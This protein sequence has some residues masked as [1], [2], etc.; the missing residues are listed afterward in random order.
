MMPC[1]FPSPAAPELANPFDPAR[2]EQYAW[3]LDWWLRSQGD[4]I[5]VTRPKN[6]LDRIRESLQR[7]LARYDVAEIND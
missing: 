2:T 6:L 3:Q 5:H 1:K 4:A 7:T